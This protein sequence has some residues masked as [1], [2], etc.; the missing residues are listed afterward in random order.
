MSCGY[1]ALYVF[2]M[3]LL[4][5]N[6]QDEETNSK[7]FAQLFFQQEKYNK[8]LQNSSLC[9]PFFFLK[10]TRIKIRKHSNRP[11]RFPPP[12]PKKKPVVPASKILKKNNPS[13]KKI[14]WL[15]GETRIYRK[16][17]RVFGLGGKARK[18]LNFQAPFWIFFNSPNLAVFGRTH[19]FWGSCPIP[20]KEGRTNDY[21]GSI[22][23]DGA[24]WLHPT[25]SRTQQ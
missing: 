18:K 2:S 13:Q 12:P 23:L 24:T 14:P 7:T 8:L 11:T 22:V 9:N 16:R 10:K 3:S 6:F 20:E 25:L 15:D 4:L 17:V 19:L 21:I 1:F 5:R